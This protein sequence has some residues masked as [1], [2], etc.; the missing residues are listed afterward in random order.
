MEDLHHLDMTK[1]YSFHSQEMNGMLRNAAG[2]IFPPKRICH[3]S[4]PIKMLPLPSDIELFSFLVAF[5]SL[6]ALN[7]VK[8]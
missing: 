1:S 4:L 6:T 8:N 2:H 7:M 5:G 3:Y